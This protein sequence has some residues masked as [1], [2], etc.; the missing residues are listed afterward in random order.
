MDTSRNTID[1]NGKGKKLEE[2]FDPG[3]R[4]FIAKSSTACCPAT[5][6]TTGVLEQKRQRVSAETERRFML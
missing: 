1:K 5:A 2:P 4:L 3:N 6:G